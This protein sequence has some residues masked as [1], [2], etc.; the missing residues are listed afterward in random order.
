MQQGDRLKASTLIVWCDWGCGVQSVHGLCI[1][2]GWRMGE[3]WNHGIRKQIISR[4]YGRRF[5]WFMLAKVFCFQAFLRQATLSESMNDCEQIAAHPH[6][7]NPDWSRRRMGCMVLLRE[8]QKSVPILCCCT[9]HGW[10]WRGL[11]WPG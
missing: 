7:L 5:S 10:S 9:F 2:M 4:Q 1:M 8:R 11:A 6:R 3:G